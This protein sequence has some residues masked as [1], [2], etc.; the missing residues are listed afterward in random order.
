[1]DGRLAYMPKP[2]PS[3]YQAMRLRCA[4]R[5]PHKCHPNA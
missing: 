3:Q 5:T 4:D 1:M 2:K